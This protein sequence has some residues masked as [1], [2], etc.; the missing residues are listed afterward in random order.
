MSA[1]RI[2]MADDQRLFR[3]GVVQLLALHPGFEVV[4][5]AGNG[6]EAIQL[7]RETMPDVI[8]MDIEMPQCNGLE[9]TTQIKRELPHAHIIMLTV[10]D[11]A[12]D[13]FAA[14]KNGADGYLLKDMDPEQLYEMLEGIERGEPP[15]A[16]GVAAKIL[17]QV[18]AFNRGDSTTLN[19]PGELSPREIEVLELVVEGR[20]NKEIASRLGIAED[21]VRNHLRNVLRKLQVQNRIQAAVYAVRQ[22]LVDR[23]VN[24]TIR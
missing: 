2:L 15:F 11:D 16:R 6:L 7:A 24:D 13:M 12:H 19:L 5:E 22:G 23:R 4:A 17:D 21:T 1:L 3:K 10:S 18:R 14:V 9:A 20:T 8:L